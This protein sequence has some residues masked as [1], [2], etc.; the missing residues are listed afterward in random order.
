MVK[1]EQCPRTDHAGRPLEDRLRGFRPGGGVEGIGPGEG[2]HAQAVVVRPTAARA[3]DD[4]YP[5]VPLEY[6]GA[7]VDGGQAVGSP[8][9]FPGVVRTGDQR[10]PGPDA[11]RGLHFGDVQLLTLVHLPLPARPEEVPLP[12][13]GEHRPVD[14]PLPGC[15]RHRPGVAESAADAGPFR[16]QGVHAVVRVLPV[17]RGKV[18]VP[19]VVDPVQFRRPDLLAVGGARGRGP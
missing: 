19:A 10:P 12:A 4:V 11:G 15:F 16:Y 2:E 7:L 18:D 5:A 9:L 13:V 3:V 17:V 8:A 6:L 14:R 1:K